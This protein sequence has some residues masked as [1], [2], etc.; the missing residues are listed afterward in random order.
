MLVLTR[1]LDEQIMIGNDIKVTLIR[2]RGNTVRIGIEAPKDIRIVRGE[3][4]PLAEANDEGEALHEREM[5]FAHPQ[6]S[7]PA[8]KQR[9]ANKR[10][11][12]KPKTKTQAPSRMPETV[13]RIAAEANAEVFVG[14]VKA[15]GGQAQIKRAPLAN[16]VSAS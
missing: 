10:T 1:K 7:K 13:S 2:V 6:L 9:P 11:N 5:A 14:T 12:S 16:F 15:S 4:E 3:L 8:A